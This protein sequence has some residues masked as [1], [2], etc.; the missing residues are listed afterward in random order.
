LPEQLLDQRFERWVV[1]RATTRS[2]LQRAYHHRFQHS[3]KANKH[4]SPLKR[5]LAIIVAADPAVKRLG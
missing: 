2:A 4:Q 5:T 3:A 1:L